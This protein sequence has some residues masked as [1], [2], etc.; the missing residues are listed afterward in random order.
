VVARP[1]AI[2]LPSPL[3]Q[4]EGETSA[5]A[6]KVMVKRDDLLPM[7]GGGNKVRKWWH[8]AEEVAA[9]GCDAVVT[10]GGIESNHCRVAALVCADRG[11]RCHL[12]LHGDPRALHQSRGN[13]FLALLAGAEASVVEPEQ[14]GPAMD[15]AMNAFSDAGRRPYLV[16]GGGHCLAGAL[17]Y[18]DA[19]HELAQQ[20]DWPAAGPDWIVVASGTGATQAGIVAGVS[21]LGWATRVVGVSVARRNPR[22]S[23]GIAASLGEVAARLGLKG[24]A[25]VEFRD[26]WVG[27][28]YGQAD[29]RVLTTISSAARQWGLILDPTYTG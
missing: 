10:C 9:A 21:S 24:V 4:L 17:A 18:H 27:A 23:E 2:C 25:P 26:E 13:A 1:S 22:G 14:V 19:V 29:E 20:H 28:G 11:W 15:A 16:P 12:V 8:I 3:A 7:S 5:L 6:C